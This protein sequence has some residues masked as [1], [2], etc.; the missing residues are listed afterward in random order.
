MILIFGGAYQGKLE[1]AKETFGL[2]EE[3]IHICG[4]GDPV[5]S[6]DHRAVQTH[7]L[8]FHTCPAQQIQGCDGFGFFKAGA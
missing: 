6:G 5:A 2:T 3:D 8:Y 1:F 7:G 4:N